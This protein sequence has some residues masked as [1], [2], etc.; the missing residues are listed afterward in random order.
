MSKFVSSIALVGFSVMGTTLA[1]QAA[2]PSTDI[3]LVPIRIQNDKPAIGRPANITHRTGYDNQPSFTPDSKSVLFTSVREDAQADIYRYDLATRST[4]RITSTP[5]SE[6]S[7]TVYGDGT[8]FTVI[9]VEPDSTQRLW[10]FRLDGSDPR[11]VFEAIKPVGYHA[12]VDSTTI[13]MFL[14]GRPNALVVADTRGGR[15]DTVARDVGR[16]LLP[17]PNG[18]GFSFVQ[19]MADSSWVLMAV[20]VRGSGAGR[21]TT[22]MPLVRMP[23]GADYVVWVRPAVA[24]TASGTALWLWR[25]RDGKGNWSKLVELGELGL[26][27]ISRLALSPDHRWLALV[28]EPAAKEERERPRS[29]RDSK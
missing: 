7:A 28:A 15:I 11:V 14:L 18:G 22:A 2:P 9:R 10:S 20:D 25:G 27:R 5:E 3:F 23:P 13:A 4:R 21:R 29:G 16:S 6:Y 12:W 1:A 26:R 8:R 19:R 24:I 17:L